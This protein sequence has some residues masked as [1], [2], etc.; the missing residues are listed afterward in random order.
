MYVSLDSI[1]QGVAVHRGMIY[2]SDPDYERVYS[3][4]E[5]G[6]NQ[7]TLRSNLRGVGALKAYTERHTTGEFQKQKT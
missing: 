3:V 6:G 4:D 7:Q 1:H 2:Y 5:K